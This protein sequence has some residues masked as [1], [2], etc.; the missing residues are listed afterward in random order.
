MKGQIILELAETPRQIDEIAS[1]ADCIWREHYAGILKE[2]QIDYM[3]E[4]F[5]SAAAIQRQK[6]EQ[7]YTYFLIEY[8]GKNAGFFGYQTEGGKLFLSKLYLLKEFR[9]KGLASIVL[10]YL[11][12]ICLERKL[13]AIWLTVNKQNTASICVYEK[14]GFRTVREQTTDIGKG[15][16]M[17]D[18]IMELPVS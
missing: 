2:E 7:G 9:R 18:Y 11:K 6:E 17:D 1:L 10:E 3:L 4:T 8:H 14:K 16:V 13:S 12:T 5:Q 15:F